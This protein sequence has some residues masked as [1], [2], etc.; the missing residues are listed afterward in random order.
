LVQLPEDHESI[1]KARC[2]AWN[3]T[4][5][6]IEDAFKKLILNVQGDSSSKEITDLISD[7]ITNPFG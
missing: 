7:A 3:D 2:Q 1:I 5:P 6:R 4:I